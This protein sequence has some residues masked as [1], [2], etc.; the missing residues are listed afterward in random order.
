MESARPKEANVAQQHVSDADLIM[1]ID[2]EL[3]AGRSR[4][5]DEHLRACWQCRAR[6]AQYERS[7]EE[8]V[9]WHTSIPVPPG[10]GPRALLRARLAQ[11]EA[12]TPGTGDWWRKYAFAGVAAAAASIAVILVW[13]S[14]TRL[15]AATPDPVRTP[16]ATVPTTLKEVCQ[17]EF[18][19]EGRRISPALALRVFHAY[20]IK[21]P[22]PRRYEVDYLITPA[23]GG[24]D[25]ERNIW[26][27]P[28]SA[29]VWNSHVKDA[30]EDHLRG[31]VCN[32]QL[33]LTDAQREISEDWVAAYQ[34]H[35]HTRSP[36][37]GHAGFVKDKPWE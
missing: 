35:F 6:R 30:L 26:P 23:L 22:G 29:G 1:A 16:G 20:G 18:Q 32:G 13:G 34:R 10:D 27:Q 11:A 3:S 9:E 36:L 17:H 25:D 5:V 33:D 31:L 24:A 14:S 7:I 8:F 4:Q 2:G 12:E 21:N 28:Y 19:D 15:I 37:A